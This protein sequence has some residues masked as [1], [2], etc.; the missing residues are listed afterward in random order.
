[1]GITPMRSDDLFYGAAS[2]DPQPDWVNLDKVAIPQADEQQRLL[3]NLILSMNSDRKLLPRFWYFPHG[4]EAVVVMTGDDH[5]GLWRSYAV[6]RFNQYLA[7]SPP[8]GSVDDWEAI[9]R[10]FLPFPY[11]RRDEDAQVVFYQTNGFEIN[12]H[13]NTDCAELHTAQALARR[14]SPINSIS[15]K[16]STRVWPSPRRIEFTALRGAATPSCRRWVREFGIRLDTSYYYWPPAWVADR[17][18]LFTGLGYAHAFCGYER[19]R[20]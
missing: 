15:S 13:L 3:A 5:A 7:A 9:G 11:R 14:V 20:D 10:H 6:R 18:G 1:M 17:P 8:G 16:P 19:Q 4:H 12:L 2:F